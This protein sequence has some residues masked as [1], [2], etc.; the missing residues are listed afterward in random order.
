MF[1]RLFGKY[2][3]WYGHR[4]GYCADLD[5]ALDAYRISDGVVL[6]CGARELVISH[7]A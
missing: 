3:V 5:R 1:A 7:V 6:C 4:I 2:E